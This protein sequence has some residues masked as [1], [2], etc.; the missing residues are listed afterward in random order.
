MNA[1]LFVHHSSLI[2][3]PSEQVPMNDFTASDLR[4]NIASWAVPGRCVPAVVA[5]LTDLLPR[6]VFDPDF[7]GQLLRTTYFDTPQFDL[8]KARHQ[9]RK[10][11]TLRIRQYPHDIFALSAKTED[12]KWRQALAPDV[13]AILLHGGQG[14]GRL[15]PGHL[16]ARAQELTGGAP[17]VP[18]VAVQACR[19]AVEDA[20]DRLTLDVDVST[21]T[22]KCLES[23][24]LEFKSTDS[25]T[26]PPGRLLALN[27]RPIKLS[28][29][30]WATL[31]R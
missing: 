14:F 30:L 28:K 23:A 15:L 24:V 13:A 1:E 7:E 18:V 17:L 21:D 31:W 20:R 16:L 5:R 19:Y 11:L 29:F 12:E 26:S 2:V 4:C 22:G 3:P 27:L 25:H 9:G 8:R 6:E 10:Y